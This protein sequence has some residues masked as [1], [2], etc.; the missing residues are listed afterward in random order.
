MTVIRSS[1]EAVKSCITWLIV[2]YVITG[3]GVGMAAP[4]RLNMLCLSVI[5][6][7]W[8]IAGIHSLQTKEIDKV[9]NIFKVTY[10]GYALSTINMLNNFT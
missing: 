9:A 4:A 1:D 6:R 10:R 7:R 5:I 8:Y 3:N 2:S